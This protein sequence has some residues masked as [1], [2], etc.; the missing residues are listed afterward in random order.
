VDGTRGGVHAKAAAEAKRVGAQGGGVVGDGASAR[1]SSAGS[2][3][4]ELQDSPPAAQQL[5]R[6]A[7]P[8]PSA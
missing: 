3:R 8:P 4:R 1:A 5:V 6:L 2:T 7:R